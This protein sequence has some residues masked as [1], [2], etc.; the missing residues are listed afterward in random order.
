MHVDP[1]RHLQV[2]AHCLDQLLIPPGLLGVRYYS[3]ALR[4]GLIIHHSRDSKRAATVRLCRHSRSKP[5]AVSTSVYCGSIMFNALFTFTFRKGCC[6]MVRHRELKLTYG[7][8]VLI[9]VGE[10]TVVSA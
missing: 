10:Q 7:K 6:T 2:E 3:I 8:V 1:E 5:D 9:F 4:H